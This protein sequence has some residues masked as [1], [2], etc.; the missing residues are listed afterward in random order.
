MTKKEIVS[1]FSCTQEKEFYTRMMSVVDATF[2]N[3]VKIGESLEESIWM[4]K[5]IKTL[6]SSG[7]FMFP[8]QKKRRDCSVL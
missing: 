3:L 5:I 8:K 1:V 6:I 2:T 4:G 7:L